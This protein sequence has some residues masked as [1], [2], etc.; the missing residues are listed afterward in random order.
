MIFSL[1]FFTKTKLLL[2][3]IVHSKNEIFFFKSRYTF[4]CDRMDIPTF[5]YDDILFGDR[6][7]PGYSYFRLQWFNKMK[8]FFFQHP[9]NEV[10]I[11]FT[12]NTFHFH[13]NRPFPS[14]F[15]IDFSSK[16]EGPNCALSLFGRVT[17]GPSSVTGVEVRGRG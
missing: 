14:P 16:P 6:Y 7:T 10:F 13:S 15:Y 17:R 9:L 3:T 1:Y 4:L 8:V 11:F 12:D 2:L 5:V